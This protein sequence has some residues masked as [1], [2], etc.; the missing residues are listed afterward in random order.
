MT[1]LIL[2]QVHSR[3]LA[4]TVKQQLNTWVY[5]DSKSSMDIF[6]TERPFEVED[7]SPPQSPPISHDHQWSRDIEPLVQQTGAEEME[8]FIG[9]QDE[10][11]WL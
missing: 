5:S 2:S 9:I 6:A 1:A 11:W 8:V 3:S 7:L 10:Q 4:Q